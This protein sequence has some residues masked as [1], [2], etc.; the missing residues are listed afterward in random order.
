MKNRDVSIIVIIEV[1]IILLFNFSSKIKV[2][3]LVAIASNEAT[4]IAFKN[5][6]KSSTIKKIITIAIAIKKYVAFKII[7]LDL[8]LNLI[9][10]CLDM[11]I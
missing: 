11:I 10:H 1:E 6:L 7:F 2:K 8:N 9:F 3:V 5:G 4:Q